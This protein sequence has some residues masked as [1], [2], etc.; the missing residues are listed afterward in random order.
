MQGG[1]VDY[2]EGVEITLILNYIDF[3][4]F[5]AGETADS[6]KH[7]TCIVHVSQGPCDGR[8]LQI[9]I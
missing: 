3:K 6:A 9:A 2:V 8:I 5:G 1:A 7:A 4:H